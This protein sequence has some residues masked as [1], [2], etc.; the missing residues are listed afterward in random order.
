[1]IHDKTDAPEWTN[2]TDVRDRFGAKDLV[3]GPGYGSFKTM[4]VVHEINPDD[5]YD[6]ITHKGVFWDLDE[7]EEY[8]EDRHERTHGYVKWDDD[9]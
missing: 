4:Y 6:A 7:A 5:K 2:D 8:A 9:G 3:I 1:M